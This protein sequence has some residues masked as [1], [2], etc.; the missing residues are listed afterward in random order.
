MDGPG[1]SVLRR[2]AVVVRV[3]VTLALAAALVACGGT[4]GSPPA[5]SS[6]LPAVYTAADDRRYCRGERR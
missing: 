1:A 2:G 3:A 4:A 5:S 6:P